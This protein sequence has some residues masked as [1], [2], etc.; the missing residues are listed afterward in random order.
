LN[1]DSFPIV[2]TITVTPPIATGSFAFQ[3]M[4]LP[5]GIAVPNSVS[6]STDVPR[7]IERAVPDEA[8]LQKG[9]VQ[10]AFP[11][12]AQTQGSAY[13][14]LAITNPIPYRVKV[15]LTA[16]DSAGNVIS[17]SGIINPVNIVMPRSGQFAEL[18]GQIFGANF[19]ASSAGTIVATGSTSILP[20]FYMAGGTISAHDLDGALADLSPISEFVM[21]T[22]FHAGTSPVTLL[23]LFN[24]GTSAATA[25]LKLYDSSGALKATATVTVPAGG[26]QVQDLRTIFSGIDLSSLSAGYVTGTTTAGLVATETFG[27]TLDSNVLRAQVAVPRNSLL[28]PHFVNGGGYSTELN[29]INMDTKVTANLTLTAFDSTGNAIGGNPVVVTLAPGNQYLRTVDQIFPALASGVTTGYIR[30]DCTPYYVG[31]WSTTTPIVGSLRFTSASGGGSTALPIYLAPSAGFVYSHVAQ[32]LGYF[33]GIAMIN[34]NAA[35]TTVTVQ[36][37]NQDGSSVGSTSVQL[38]PGQKL[39]KLVS[40]LVPASA[41]QVGGYVSVQSTLPI[42]SFSLFGTD[43]GKLLSAIPPQ[44]IQ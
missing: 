17:G 4:L 35:A 27:N 26:T 21:P 43:E 34:P 24:P 11:F 31:P 9:T 40:E 32:D 16:Y 13:T 44:N 18:A 15:T 38:Q 22:V 41:G 12:P 2:V 7:Y 19:N 3:G 20:G 36:V 6:P 30:I 29:L 33:S 39:A 37:F 10:L 5:I 14:G 28:V 1:L 23:R 42:T 8:D 25:T